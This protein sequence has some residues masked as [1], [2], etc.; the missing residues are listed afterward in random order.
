MPAQDDAAFSGENAAAFSGENA[1]SG[2]TAAWDAAVHASLRRA[3]HCA[4]CANGV[5]ACALAVPAALFMALLERASGEH[6]GVLHY[7]LYVLAEARAPRTAEASCALRGR[8]HAA[9]LVAKHSR[10]RGCAKT[11]LVELLVG[12]YSDALYEISARRATWDDALARADAHGGACPQN[13]VASGLFASLD[14]F[15]HEA[16]PTR[17]Y[18]YSQAHREC[19]GRLK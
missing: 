17:A 8:M 12:K 15:M 6:D 5:R 4:K 7:T 18:A 13:E 10:S 2:E 9:L 11:A 19:N 1:F 3:A 14:A 16:F